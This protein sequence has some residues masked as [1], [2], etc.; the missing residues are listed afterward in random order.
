MKKTMKQ[1]LRQLGSAELEKK[2]HQAQLELAKAKLALAVGKLKNT[3]VRLMA[4]KIAV[5]K[6]IKKEKQLNAKK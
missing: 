4:D 5:I 3:H 2:L 1:S 6:T